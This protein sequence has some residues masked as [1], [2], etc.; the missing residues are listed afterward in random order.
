MPA[1]TIDVA[2][3][4]V[5]AIPDNATVGGR[6]HHHRRGRHAEEL[7]HGVAGRSDPAQHLG[8]QRRTRSRVAN[9]AIFQLGTDGKLSV[10]NQQGTVNVIMDVTG[11]FVAGGPATTTT[12]THDHTDD[13]HDRRRRR[14]D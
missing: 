11:Y 3:A 12:T 2:V 14:T 7:P 13:D 6:Q 10:F 1:E 4:G 9:S 5:G 8:Q